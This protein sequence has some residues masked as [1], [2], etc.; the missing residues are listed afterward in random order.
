MAG[1]EDTASLLTDTEGTPSLELVC[2]VATPPLPGQRGIEDTP[3][4]LGLT[5][6]EATPLHSD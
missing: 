6:T 3:Y 2:A 5:G 1:P 4:L